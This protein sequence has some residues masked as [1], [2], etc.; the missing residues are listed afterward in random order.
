MSVHRYTHRRNDHFQNLLP[1]DIL[2]NE[3][4]YAGT[5]YNNDHLGEVIEK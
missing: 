4:P 5:G 2:G 3:Y 1:R